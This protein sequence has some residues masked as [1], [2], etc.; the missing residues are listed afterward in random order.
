MALQSLI[1][2]LVI[3]VLLLALGVP[4]AVTIALSAMGAILPVMPL[5]VTV[6]TAAQ[7]IFSG[8]STFTLVAIPFFV[9]AGNIMNRSEEHTS[10]LQ[11]RFDLVCRLLLEKKKNKKK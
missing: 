10:E 6:V 8:T 5:D 2:M 3:L 7:R 4:I 11:S 1:I 9:L